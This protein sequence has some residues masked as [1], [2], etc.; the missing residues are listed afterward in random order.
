MHAVRFSIDGADPRIGRLDGDTV[1]DAGPAGPQGFVPTDEAWSAL[2]AASGAVAAL[3]SV[4][5]HAPLIPRQVL[6]IGLNYRAHAIESDIPIPE[7]PVV[8]AMYPSSI[9]GPHDEIVIPHEETRTDYEGEVAVVISRRAYRVSAADAWSYVGAVTALDDVS[10]RRAQLETP[11]RQF[12]LGKSF[13]TFTPIGP[14]LARASEFDPTDI[15][16]STR[17]SGELMQDSS[18]SDLIFSI[19]EIIEYL[20]RGMTLEPGDLI[21]TGTPGG[22]GDSRVPPRYLVE[23]DVVEIT[24]DGVGSLRNPVRKER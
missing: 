24:V 18:T 17:V 9:T 13:D 1:V 7:V 21:A 5:L 12:T 10:G 16:V 11:L 20:T 23:G 3:G 22:V 6:A 8:F 2:A 4:R 19:A 14:S 15:H